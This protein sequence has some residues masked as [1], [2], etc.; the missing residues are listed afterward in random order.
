MKQKFYNHLGSNIG[1]YLPIKKILEKIVKIFLCL[2]DLQIN[3]IYIWLIEFIE[4]LYLEKNLHICKFWGVTKQTTHFQKWTPSNI[5][6]NALTT[7]D[8][9]YGLQI[10]TFNL[11]QIH[12]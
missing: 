9:I 4:F 2:K 7:H 5:K 10:Q 6:P 3:K 12:M 1:R 8:V 11:S